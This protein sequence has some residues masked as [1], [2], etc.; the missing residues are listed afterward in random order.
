MG[1]VEGKYL[2]AALA[3]GN[4]RL[5]SVE[6]PALYDLTVE[7]RNG[8][9]VIDRVESYFGVREVSIENGRVCIN[10]RPVYLKFLLDQGYWPESL[11]TPPSDEAIQYRGP[12]LPLLGRQDGLPGFGRDRQRVPL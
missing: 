6:R 5:W 4:P 1:V 3:I 10:H 2:N 8:D 12:A 7:I 11:L 9:T